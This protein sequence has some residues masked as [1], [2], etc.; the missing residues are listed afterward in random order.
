MSANSGT[1]L[2]TLG[3]QR[4]VMGYACPVCHAPQA[5]GE[6][7]ANHL[8]FSALLGHEDHAAWLDEHAPGW[9]DD[10]PDELA[11][12]VTPHA[13][14]VEYPEVFED[15]TEGAAPDVSEDLLQSGGHAGPVE[16]GPETQRVIEE[17][18]ELT[19]RR[20]DD[21]DESGK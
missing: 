18:R 10:G 1:A 20:R 4:G 19:R 11:E 3:A 5:D 12:R 8:A 16:P 21:E 15:T 7:L 2:F 14:E 13:D 6:H 17:A 9:D